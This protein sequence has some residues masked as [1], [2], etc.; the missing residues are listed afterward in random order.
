MKPKG[1]D[2]S[3]ECVDLSGLEPSHSHVPVPSTPAEVVSGLWPSI[4]I[5]RHQNVG[6]GDYMEAMARSPEGGHEV[7]CITRIAND[8]YSLQPTPLSLLFPSIL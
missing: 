4:Q 8:R 2:T 7:P 5:P 3:M 1:G 6:S